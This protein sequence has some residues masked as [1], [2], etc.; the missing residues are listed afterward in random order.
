VG[1]VIGAFIAIRRRAH[2]ATAEHTLPE[3]YR[4][5]IGLMAGLLATAVMSLGI[6]LLLYGLAALDQVAPAAALV[7]LGHAVGRRVGARPT[8]V[9]TLGIA[10][11]VAVQLIWAVVYAHVER[12]LPEP[13]WLGG[14]LFALLPL[15]FSTLVVLPALG[16]GVAGSGLGM[17]LMPLAGEVVRHALYGASLA[18]AY[19]LLSRARAA[20]RRPMAPPGEPVAGR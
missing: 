15:G 2:L 5:E 16:A 12:W 17:G 20:R 13:D 14:L 9:L 4:L 18:I 19:T 10:T 11:F 8:L 6:D 1:A 3:Q 7:E